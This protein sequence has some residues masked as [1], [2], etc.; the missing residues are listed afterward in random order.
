MN[1]SFISY[2]EIFDHIRPA[3]YRST[4]PKMAVFGIL[5]VLLARLF[6]GELMSQINAELVKRIANVARIEISEEEANTF[7]NELSTIVSFGEQLHELDTTEV[8]PTTHVTNRKNVLRDDTVV[9][10]LPI[11]DVLK[12]APDHEDGQIRVPT[13]LE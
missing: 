12:N 2:N 9:E 10:G 3:S 7:A 5:Y 11:E 4:L 8:E 6:G 13:I 1:R